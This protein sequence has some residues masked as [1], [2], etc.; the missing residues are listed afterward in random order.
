MVDTVVRVQDNR[1]VFSV[2]VAPLAGAVLAQAAAASDEATAAAALATTK[3]AEAV[4]AAADAVAATVDKADI[5]DLT[6]LTAS[7]PTTWAA[8]RVFD[9]TRF[10][11]GERVNELKIY[12]SPT[13]GINSTAQL[14]VNNLYSDGTKRVFLRDFTFAEGMLRVKLIRGNFMVKVTDPV[15][16]GE[17]ALW[18]AGTNLEVGYI[19]P[20]GNVTSIGTPNA[21]AGSGSDAIWI[22]ML[23]GPMA[24]GLGISARSWKDGDP[25]PATP[26][27]FGNFGSGVAGEQINEGQ[28][29]FFTLTGGT[30]KYLRVEAYD[31][32]G[33]TKAT[34]NVTLSG[35]WFPGFEGG[36]NVMRTIRTG[37][38]IRFKAS[39]TANVA[40]EFS[41]VA[42]V[43]GG[44]VPVA[45]AFVNGVRT[46]GAITFTNGGSAGLLG[47]SVTLGLDPAVVSDVELRLRGLHE[48]NDKFLKAGGLALYRVTPATDGGVIA[49]WPD[50]R[51][52]LMG[53]GDSTMEPV[54]VRGGTST[55]TNAG[56][57]VSWLR[58]AADQMGYKPIHNGFGGTGV[59]GGVNSGVAGTTGSGDMPAAPIN[60]RYYMRGRPIN[61]GSVNAKIMLFNHGVNDRAAFLSIGHPTDPEWQAAAQAFVLQA[62]QDHPGLEHFIFMPS[63]AAQLYKTQMQ[64]VV[65]A[66][67]DPRVTMFDTTAL[68]ATLTFTDGVHPNLADQALIA[69]AVVTY[70]RSLPAPVFS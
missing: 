19:D 4:D 63:F 22:E 54:V 38:S 2:P 58:Q 25:R 61:F 23:V 39:G 66:L 12:G 5:V 56:G 20:A 69:A 47:V 24:N 67:G 50:D 15:L 14:E 7:S 53:V 64:A 45:D 1:A 6:R 42:G 11:E 59:Y 18:S 31:G 21:L 49:P 37:D 44:Y 9:F 33:G 70:I 60:A 43:V 36:V 68:G 62:F 57:D 40:V 51:P 3:A 17:R 8:P 27:V 30:A 32:L 65:T 41:G 28:V 48:H 10:V 13:A 52:A 26:D 16:G 34:G 29:S 55:P 35:L 46:G